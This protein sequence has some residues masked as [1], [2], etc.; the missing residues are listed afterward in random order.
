MAKQIHQ[1]QKRTALLSS[2]IVW[3]LGLTACLPQDYA[4]INAT[5]VK[6]ICIA[7]YVETNSDTITLDFYTK[8]NGIETVEEVSYTLGNYLAAELG[9]CDETFY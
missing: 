9:I 4:K 8:S 5:E 3:I 7:G 6:Q 1:Y 2:S